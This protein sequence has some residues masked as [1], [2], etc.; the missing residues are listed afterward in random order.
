MILE[1][2]TKIGKTNQIRHYCTKRNCACPF[3]YK[4]V[5]ATLNYVINCIQPPCPYYNYV[6]KANSCDAC[7]DPEVW[8]YT[9]GKCIF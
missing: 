4:P 5:C 7:C 2:Y 6:S 1:I 3:I 8:Y 9:K